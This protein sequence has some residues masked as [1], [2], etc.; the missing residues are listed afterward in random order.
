MAI[1]PEGDEHVD[2]PPDNVQSRWGDW[3]AGLEDA[4]A[5]AGDVHL[6]TWQIATSANQ[7]A[8]EHALAVDQLLEDSKG[9]GSDQETISDQMRALIDPENENSPLWEMMLDI[10]E[11]QRQRD[12]AQDEAIDQLRQLL[13]ERTRDVWH[14]IFVDRWETYEDDWLRIDGW[15]DG[16][17]RRITARDDVVGP[18][19]GKYVYQSVYSGTNPAPAIEGID[20]GG[21]LSRV[22]R[23]QAFQEHASV[24]HYMVDQG[25][26]MYHDDSTGGFSP[27]GGEWTEIP[28][29]TF[30]CPDTSE[31]LIYFRTGWDAATHHNSYG[32]RVMRN[33]TERLGWVAPR[34]GVGPLLPSIL[35]G[36]SGY[37]TQTVSEQG[38]RLT[39][40]DVVTFEL[41]TTGDEYSQ[42]R[43]RQSWV[44]M[45]WIKPP[46]VGDQ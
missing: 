18:W 32:V 5:A 23:H 37:R 21:T 40:G 15:G 27:T 22:Q 11:L 17:D 20:V 45:S 14:T 12:T 16:H 25:T 29:L 4:G 30:E 26:A 1:K 46:E 34:T 24:V 41:W 39:E 33:G 19:V 7:M 9:I 31:Y 43:S 36:G 28:S 2:I 6:E 42:R 38:L 3:V 13:E 10:E 35:G 44:Q 8:S